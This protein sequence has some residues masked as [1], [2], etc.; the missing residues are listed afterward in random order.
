MELYVCKTNHGHVEMIPDN[1][2]ASF[3]VN[4]NTNEITIRTSEDVDIEKRVGTCIVKESFK[5]VWTGKSI[6]TSDGM[7]YDKTSLV[8]EMIKQSEAFAEKREY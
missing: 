8:K 3:Q 7:L 5:H 1:K 6:R 2:I 4:P